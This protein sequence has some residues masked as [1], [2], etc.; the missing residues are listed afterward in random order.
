MLQRRLRG[1]A[2]RVHCTQNARRASLSLGRAGLGG[3]ELT[4][5]ELAHRRQHVALELSNSNLDA[6]YLAGR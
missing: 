4:P 2:E 5:A 3:E 6:Q 1:I